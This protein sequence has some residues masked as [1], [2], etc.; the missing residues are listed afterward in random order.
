MS[1]TEETVDS[2]KPRVRSARVIV[3]LPPDTGGK[4]Q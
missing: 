3:R 2:D 1:D 4:Y